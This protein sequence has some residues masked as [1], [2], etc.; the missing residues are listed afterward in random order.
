M[1]KITLKVIS[2]ILVLIIPLT[3]MYAMELSTN[4]TTDLETMD[5]IQ[6][7]EATIFSEFS[8][9]EPFISELK[10]NENR[11]GEIPACILTNDAIPG[12]VQIEQTPNYKTSLGI[13]SIL[14]GCA[15]GVPG[16]MFIY[17]ATDRNMKQTNNA[18]VGCFFNT[19]A[20]VFTIIT[21]S[22]KQNL[23]FNLL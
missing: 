23:S 3:P 20:L 13:P 14:W 18:F 12:F 15:L 17:A 1:K 8:E 16:V 11:T 19:V 5:I 7:E 9:I 22:E 10:T 6:F 2:F 21:I 4:T